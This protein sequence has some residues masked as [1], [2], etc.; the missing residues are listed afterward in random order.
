[1]QLRAVGDL[2]CNTATW[3]LMR[4][5]FFFPLLLQRSEGL[6]F[7]RCW[8]EKHAN[9]RW[10]LQRFFQSYFEGDL[11]RNS[12][13]GKGNYWRARKTPQCSKMRS[14]KFRAKDE[15]FLAWSEQWYQQALQ[16]VIAAVIYKNV[17][18]DTTK[19]LVL[20]LLL[21]LLLSEMTLLRKSGNDFWCCYCW[22]CCC[23][24]P[25]AELHF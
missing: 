9:S 18:L 15:I 11:I 4:L 2:L 19:L 23:E 22:C 12:V 8:W 16:H 24:W 6:R 3:V 13:W 14:I 7:H 10:E 5:V 25:R 1:M 17:H 21:P 20:L